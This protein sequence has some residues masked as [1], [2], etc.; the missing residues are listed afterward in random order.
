MLGLC[1]AQIMHALVAVEVPERLVEGPLT[2]AELAGTTDTHEPSLRRLLRAAVSLGLIEPTDRGDTMGLTAD[3]RLLTRAAPGSIRNLVLLWGGE[4]VWRSWGKLA[5]SVRTG[6]T[7]YDRVMGMSLFDHH[8]EHPDEQEVFDAAMAES[9][10]VA[11]PGVVDACDLD[12]RGRVVDVGGGSGSLLTAMLTARPHLTGVLFD[13]PSNTNA[14]LAEIERAGVGDRAEV[15]GGDFFVEVPEGGDAY[16]LKSVLHDWD[17]AR[18]SQILAN[19]HSSMDADAVL[20]VVEPIVPEPHEA[21]ADQMMMVI[22]DLN[23][24]VCTGGVERSAPEYR[25]LLEASGF[26]LTDIAR[27]A[28]PSNL[29]V[30]RAIPT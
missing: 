13:R 12:D 26:H 21:V 3:G 20:N 1:P 22:S 27:C 2:T 24:L 17:D 18:C 8:R 23:M 10:R 5:N 4:G 11:A 30:V 29:S 15:V 14:G 25:M 28:A 19:C 16:V 7:A 9:S 6:Q